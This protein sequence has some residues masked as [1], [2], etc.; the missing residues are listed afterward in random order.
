M[1]YWRHYVKMSS[2]NRGHSS[3]NMATT[4]L[5]PPRLEASIPAHTGRPGDQYIG[6]RA[7]NRPELLIV[8]GG[9]HLKLVQKHYRNMTMDNYDLPRTLQERGVADVDKLPRYY[10]RGDALLLWNAIHEYVAEIVGI[11]TIQ[12][13]ATSLRFQ[14][15]RILLNRRKEPWGFSLHENRLRCNAFDDFPF[16]FAIEDR[17]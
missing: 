14:S 15:A 17:F 5:A 12:V 1:L 16:G 9:G 11:C 2:G 10:Y 8:G 7:P 13:T 3:G 6:P 4:P